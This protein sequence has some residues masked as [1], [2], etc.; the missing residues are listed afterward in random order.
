[1][2]VY[3]LCGISVDCKYWVKYY[4][5]NHIFSSCN[6]WKWLFKLSFT[7][8]VI[9]VHYILSPEWVPVYHSSLPFQYYMSRCILV[10]NLGPLGFGPTSIFMTASLWSFLAWLVN[11]RSAVYI[12]KCC[13]LSTRATS[14]PIWSFYSGSE[15]LYVQGN[16]WQRLLVYI[17]HICQLHMMRHPDKLHYPV[18]F[19]SFPLT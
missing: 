1:M 9:L 17:I 6:L 18:R 16:I 14:F 10:V 4:L 3:Q 12:A 13:T 19:I 8:Y 15:I 5:H 7:G 11:Y 2:Y